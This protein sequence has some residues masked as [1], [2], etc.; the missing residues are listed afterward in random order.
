MMRVFSR[1]RGGIHEADLP[2]GRLLEAEAERLAELLAS[3]T[4]YI[5]EVREF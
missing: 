4:V 1:D 5:Q 3:K 2:K